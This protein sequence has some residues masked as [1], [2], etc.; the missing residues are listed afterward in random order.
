MNCIQL[1]I[2]AAEKAFC[3]I[4]RELLSKALPYASEENKVYAFSCAFFI[5]PRSSYYFG[6]LTLR[7]CRKSVFFEQRFKTLTC[8]F[9]RDALSFGKPCKY[10][11][12]CRNSFSVSKLRLS[13][14]LF[15]RISECMS[16]IEYSAFSR[17]AFIILHY[18]TLY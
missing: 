4:Y 13:A 12:A 18:I 6:K 8:A 14:R 3:L 5:S 7:I 2:T 16:K 9:F 11:R 1:Y 15:T 17:V 10:C